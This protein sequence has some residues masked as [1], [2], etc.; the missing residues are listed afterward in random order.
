MTSGNL[1]LFQV[2][3]VVFINL[4]TTGIIFGFAALKPVLIRKGVYY[5]LCKDGRIPLL[6][7]PRSCERQ[8]L[9]LNDIFVAAVAIA[10]MASLPAGAILDR[11][12]PTRTSIL[13]AMLFGLG[14]LVFGSGRQSWPIAFDG[15]SIGFILIAIG[16][17]LIFLSSFHIS[18]SFPRRSGLI[19]SCIM[20]GFNA[21]STPYVFYNWIDQKTAGLSIKTFF[22]CYTLIPALFITLQG[23]FGPK[24]AYTQQAEVGPD[25][26]TAINGPA[27][28][29][30]AIPTDAL[31]TNT[32]SNPS[33]RPRDTARKDAF[34]GVVSNRSATEQILSRHFWVLLL[35]FSVY[36]DRINWLIQTISEQL[37]FYLRDPTLTSNTVTKFT[38]LLPIGGIVG[39]PIFGWLLDSRTVF[40]ASLVIM[41]GGFVYGVLGMLHSA[42]AQTV[43]IS[44][45]VILRPLL[46]VFV[47]DYCGKC[48]LDSHL[49]EFTG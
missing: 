26:V 2:V 42:V 1:R 38:L 16:S 29:Y 46:Y 39:V 15:Y 24:T 17:P 21:S 35:F 7:S 20:A 11:V 37:S 32:R 34:I 23:V 4:F 31:P 27:T 36:A 3:L 47:G 13:G 41:A 49:A 8:E 25:E 33:V 22:W 43:S 45:F 12:G 48:V 44:V 5:E 19:L 6:E 30:G 40:D 28:A 10:N 14:N 9:R 18:N